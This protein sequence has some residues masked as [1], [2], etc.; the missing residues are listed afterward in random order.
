[1]RPYFLKKLMFNDL[2][3]LLK[4]EELNILQFDLYSYSGLISVEK[5]KLKLL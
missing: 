1:M 4:T 2:E 3:Q 5:K